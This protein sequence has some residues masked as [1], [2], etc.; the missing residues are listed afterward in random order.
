MP[1]G[2]TADCHPGKCM[3]LN[4]PSATQLSNK[5]AHRFTLATFLAELGSGNFL[6]KLTPTSMMLDW[7]NVEK[8][9]LTASSSLSVSV[10]PDPLAMRKIFCTAS[11]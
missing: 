6:L 9:L 7:P 4:Q 8:R 5:L 3:Y 1:L 10:K 11:V 2:T